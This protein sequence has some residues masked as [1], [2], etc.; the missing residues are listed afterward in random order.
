LKK[1]AKFQNKKYC[2]SAIF[3]QNNNGC[4]YI[5]SHVKIKASEMTMAHGTFEKSNP[6]EHSG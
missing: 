5:R 4:A 3:K 2:F 6:G 1:E